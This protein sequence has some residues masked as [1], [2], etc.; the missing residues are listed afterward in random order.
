MCT[1]FVSML[2]RKANRDAARSAEEIK[3]R[4]RVTQ[5][6]LVSLGA[7]VQMGDAALFL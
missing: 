7:G 1:V 5:A 6:I 3:E 2:Q 4:A